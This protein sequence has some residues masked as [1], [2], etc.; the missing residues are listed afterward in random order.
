MDEDFFEAYPVIF[1]LDW[2][3]ENNRTTVVYRYC[4]H[5][6]EVQ[7]D[8]ENM[9]G[10]ARCLASYR[11]DAVSSWHWFRLAQSSKNS[12]LMMEC[13]RCGSRTPKMRIRRD[14]VGCPQCL[15]HESWKRWSSKWIYRIK[16]VINENDHIAI[17]EL[18]KTPQGR[19]KYNTAMEEMGLKPREITHET[20]IKKIPHITEPILTVQS[21]YLWSRK[22]QRRVFLGGE[23][24]WWVSKWDADGKLYWDKWEE[25]SSDTSAGEYEFRTIRSWPGRILLPIIRARPDIAG[26]Y[27]RENFNHRASLRRDR[28]RVASIRRADRVRSQ[29]RAK[30]LE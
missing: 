8:L 22:A 17:A 4:G 20:G 25:E 11:Q 30:G 12:T 29:R 28:R 24:G 5:L 23:M 3:V 2:P 9:F 26:N 21:K 15:T 1:C 10:W 27:I 7:F 18:L 13:P 6:L 14:T 16:A 19:T